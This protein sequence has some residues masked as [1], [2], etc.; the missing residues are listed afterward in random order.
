MAK[1]NKKSEQRAEFITSAKGRALTSA[2]IAAL[3]LLGLRG[4]RSLG[5]K[6]APEKLEA[7]SR[8]LKKGSFKIGPKSGPGISSGK[9]L[10]GKG[11]TGTEPAKKMDPLGLTGI[12]SGAAGAGLAGALFAGLD[13]DNYAHS[14]AKK[15]NANKKLSPD[16]KKFVRGVKKQLKM[17]KTWKRHIPAGVQSGPVVGSAAMAANLVTGSGIGPAVQGGAEALAD[18]ALTGSAKTLALRSRM[19][20]GKGLRPTEKDLMEAIRKARG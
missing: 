18:R 9:G 16:E 5:R 17:R 14:I 6:Y 11:S 7:L 15:H 4:I 20:S 12:L 1:A 13:R 2:G 10:F 8:V 19:K 3:S